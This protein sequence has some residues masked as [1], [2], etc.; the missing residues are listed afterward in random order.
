MSQ[1][2]DNNPHFR[3]RIQPQ[4][5]PPAVPPPRIH[6]RQRPQTPFRQDHPAD[7][8]SSPMLQTYQ[9]DPTQSLPPQPRRQTPHPQPELMPPQSAIQP[10]RQP[11]Q[12]TEQNL[13][14]PSPSKTNPITW[15]GAVF[16]FILWVVIILGGLLV[17]IIYLIY[18]PRIPHFH[19]TSATL[20]SA[21]LDTGYL[22]NA[23]LTLLANFTNPS[24]RVSV[25]FNYVILQLSY[26]NRLIADQ[27]IEPFS[28]MR[29]ESQLAN[30][31]MVS[32][33]VRLPMRVSQQLMKQME[34]NRIAFQVDGLFHARSKFGS[35][36]RYSYWLYA[37]CSIVLTGP[38]SGIMVASKC[39][40]KR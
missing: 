5:Q 21:Y 10:Q 22:L 24:S 9:P 35:V 6:P 11:P 40:T 13:M 33:Q 16:C 26:E 20:N 17:L 2:D 4:D 28:V 34:S 8:P 31:E 29:T 12:N 23:D 15:F 14:Y 3:P 37:H 32:S 1:Y 7:V 19:I 30:V 25:D 18:R 39:R 36:L 38:P 27:Y